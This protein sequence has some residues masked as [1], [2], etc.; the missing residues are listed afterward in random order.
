MTFILKTYTNKELAAMYDIPY[1]AWL[2]W[3]K[4]LK[5]KLGRNIRG[6]WNPNQVEIM[7]KHFGLPSKEIREND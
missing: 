1:N 3:I 2:V 7:I 5:E 4:P 6:K